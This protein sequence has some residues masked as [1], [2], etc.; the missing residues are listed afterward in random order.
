MLGK[1][2]ANGGGDRWCR[3]WCCQRAGGQ[4]VESA[5]FRG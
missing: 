5:E 2:W 1:E 3:E 4:V